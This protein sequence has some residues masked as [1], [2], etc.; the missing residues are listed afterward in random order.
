MV[1]VRP[2]DLFL[3]DFIVKNRLQDKHFLFHFLC[4]FCLITSVATSIF[5]FYQKYIAIQ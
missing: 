5:Y 1:C 3:V 2:M 4:S